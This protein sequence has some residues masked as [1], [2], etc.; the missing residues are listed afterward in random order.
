MKNKSDTEDCVSDTFMNLIKSAPRFRDTDHEKAWLIRAATNVCKNNLRHWSKKAVDIDECDNYLSSLAA[1][2]NPYELHEN[3]A[4]LDAV[5]GL[6]EEIRGAVYMYYY[7]GYSSVE[8][9]R[10]LDK[11]DSTI[12]NYLRK[13][14]SML[15]DILQ[16][17]SN[18]YAGT[19][20]KKKKEA[21]L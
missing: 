18:T 1:N 15:K 6:P 4:I 14:K 5:H 7:E 11:P 16:D 12:R 17:Y 20:N 3:K 19:A 13:G 9:A 8:I 2:S 21:V 10:I